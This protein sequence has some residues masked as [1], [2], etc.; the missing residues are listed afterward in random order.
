[1][2]VATLISIV[3]TVFITFPIRRVTLPRRMDFFPDGVPDD[4]TDTLEL[5]T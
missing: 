1:M 4:L 5:A 2:A 3:I